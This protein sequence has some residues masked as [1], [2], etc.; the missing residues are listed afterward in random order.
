MIS[1]DKGAQLRQEFYDIT[2]HDDTHVKCDCYLIRQRD[3]RNSRLHADN[4]TNARETS[5]TNQ[6]SRKKKHAPVQLQ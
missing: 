4:A 6:R 2:T 1:A 5:A 3:V